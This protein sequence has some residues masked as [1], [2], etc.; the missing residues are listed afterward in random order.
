MDNYFLGGVALSGA[1]AILY[2]IVRYVSTF[3]THVTDHVDTDVLS[4][5]CGTC[6]ETTLGTEDHDERCI[7]TILKKLDKKDRGQLEPTDSGLS[8]DAEKV[9]EEFS[10]FSSTL[11]AFE[12]E[13]DL[14]DMSETEDPT[15]VED[16]E[17]ACK[18][19]VTYCR[20]VLWSSF[21]S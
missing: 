7:C 3:D 19:T 16:G 6:D 1:S 9:G 20:A 17:F 11:Y 10:E 15:I 5:S 12:G 13:L 21:E 18:G 2:G 14:S 8:S 4:E